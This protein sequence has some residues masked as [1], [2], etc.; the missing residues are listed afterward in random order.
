MKIGIIYNS[1]N[2]KEALPEERE[3]R[4][5]GLAI[6]KYLARLG[7][8]V[9]YF[10]MDDPRSVEA[11]C[12]GSI[13]VAF[14]ACE[15]VHDD[16]RGEIYASALLEYLGIPHTRTS[17]WRIA[18]GISKVRVKS[19]LSYYRIPTPSFQIFRSAEQPLDP[20]LQFP[21]FVKGLAS[22]NSI[23]IDEHS[24]VHTTD[25]LRA[26]VQQVV[27]DLRQPALVEE[28]IAGRELSAAILPGVN[29]R[30]LPIS[31]IIFG[32][33]PPESRFL[34]YNSKWS[35]DSERFRKSV[36]VCPAN[37]TEAERNR[38]STTALKCYHVLGL[39]SYARID[40]RYREGTPYVLEVNQNP[41]IGE[42]DCGYVRT[43]QSAGL[44]Y[45]AIL[46][47]LLKNALVRK[48]ENLPVRTIAKHGENRGSR[49]SRIRRPE[50]ARI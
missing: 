13:D 40:M 14:N 26:K 21:L 4:D 48:S 5:T 10:D 38:I 36:P 23:G 34:D 28:Y 37:L 24:L 33:L 41:S 47:V 20:G 44:D 12:A 39:D 22:E 27:T 6:G 42:Q 18:L 30:V 46:Q 17:A 8:R 45:A 1:F 29:D 2:Y 25:E 16:A 7:Q 43:C 11:L 49:T 32:D 19:I 3:M 31:E 9:E 35:S 50:T 15:R